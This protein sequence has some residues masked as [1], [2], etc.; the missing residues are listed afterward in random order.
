MQRRHPLALG[1]YA[2]HPPAGVL[3][4]VQI[5]AYDFPVRSTGKPCYFL[6]SCSDY[7]KCAPRRKHYTRHT[8]E[9]GRS[10]FTLVS[11]TSEPRGF[12]RGRSGRVRSKL[13]QHSTMQ[14]M[15]PARSVHRS[16]VCDVFPGSN[17]PMHRY[18]PTIVFSHNV[19]SHT[20]GERRSFSCRLGSAQKVTSGI[21]ED[22]QQRLKDYH[23]AWGCDQ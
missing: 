8:I 3:P 12:I 10:N 17:S 14:D 1:H 5:A 7:R 22:F 4:N 13:E 19:S 15:P 20:T 23:T 18:I 9:S 6:L 2:N 11:A 21:A 16:D